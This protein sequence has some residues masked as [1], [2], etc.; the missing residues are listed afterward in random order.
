[1]VDVNPRDVEVILAQK[2]A[3]GEPVA[4]QRA[5]R[6]LEDWIRQ[7]SS[8][9][10]TFVFFPLLLLIVYH[11]LW[12]RQI[13]SKNSRHRVECHL[14]WL[15]DWV[16]V[17]N[18]K[19]IANLKTDFC[20]KIILKKNKFFPFNFQHFL[21]LLLSKSQVKRIL[22]FRVYWR[23]HATSLEGAAL[24]VVD[25]GQNDHAGFVQVY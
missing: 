5:L 7:Q 8:H 1:M 21:M 6:A 16:L 25:A 3:C 23:W 12:D 18:L 20:W 24:R 2:L 15:G 14:W 9:I 4:R 17:L 13:C 22:C 10:G 11:F 19:K